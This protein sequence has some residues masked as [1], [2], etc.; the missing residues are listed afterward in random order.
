MYK[1]SIEYTDTFA[2]EANYAWVKRETVLIEPRY[3]IKWLKSY[4]KKAMGL[5]GVRGKWTDY[6]D[7]LEFRPNGFAT[8]LFIAFAEEI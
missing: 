7:M 4:A 6:G 5:G 3:S 1:Y 2:G 8:V